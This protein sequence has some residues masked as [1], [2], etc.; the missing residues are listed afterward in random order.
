MR[1]PLRCVTCPTIVVW[2][3]RGL[4]RCCVQ[5]STRQERGQRKCRLET[6]NLEE[7]FPGVRAC[8]QRMPKRRMVQATTHDEHPGLR[9]NWKTCLEPLVIRQVCVGNRADSATELVVEHVQSR[10]TCTGERSNGV[11]WFWSTEGCAKE[12][13]CVVSCYEAESPN[14]PG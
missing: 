6:G 12:D 3:H 2:W 8:S 14:A 13:Q 10:V 9:F 1:I 7:S 4:R 11:V 5:L